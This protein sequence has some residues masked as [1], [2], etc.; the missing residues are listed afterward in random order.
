MDYLLNRPILERHRVLLDFNDNSLQLN[1]S[2]QI[3]I[4]NNELIGPKEH[5]RFKVEVNVVTHKVTQ[6]YELMGLVIQNEH[7]NL[8]LH[9]NGNNL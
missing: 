1:G 7:R 4:T 5:V 2:Y 3:K 9:E 6:A 8:Q